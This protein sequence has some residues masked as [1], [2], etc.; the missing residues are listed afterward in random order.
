M[1]PAYAGDPGDPSN[2]L[3]NN[4]AFLRSVRE[5]I[6]SI[7]R[8]RVH[9]TVVD[10]ESD[11]IWIISEYQFDGDPNWVAMDVGV[12]SGPAGPFESWPGCPF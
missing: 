7:N 2:Q 4:G 3:V 5:R 11:P 8:L 10:V 12:A 6:F 9:F 1:N